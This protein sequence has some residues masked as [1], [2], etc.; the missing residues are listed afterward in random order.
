MKSKETIHI[1]YEHNGKYFE[2]KERA[3]EWS[4]LMKKVKKYDLGYE[5]TEK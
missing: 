1:K 3:E 2:L 4:V 5:T